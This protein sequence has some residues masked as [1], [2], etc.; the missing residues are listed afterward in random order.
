MKDRRKQAQQPTEQFMLN[1]ID[2]LLANMEGPKDRV[3]EMS[4]IIEPK[5]LPEDLPFQRDLMAVL[6]D[7]SARSI[8]PTRQNLLYGLGVLYSR[9]GTETEAAMDA[10]LDKKTVGGDVNSLSSW[11]TDDIRRRQI[12]DAWTRGDGI[13]NSYEGTPSERLERAITEVLP[14]YTSSEGVSEERET[15]ELMDYMDEELDR[16]RD[17]FLNGAAPGPSLKFRGFTGVRNKDGS[18]KIPGKVPFLKWGQTTLVTGQSKAGKTLFGG[19][20]AEHNAW[21]LNIDVLYIHMETEQV[22]M[23]DRM[24]VRNLFIP[25]DYLG[26][27]L[28]DRKDAT[29][30]AAAKYNRFSKWASLPVKNW[31]NGTETPSGEITFL[32]CPGTT[33]YEINSAIA[34]QRRKSDAR[35]RGLLVI[36]DY[37]NLIDKSSFYGN[38]GEQLGQVAY[39]LREGIKRENSKSQAAKGLGVHC[40]VFAQESVDANGEATG[41]AGTQIVQYSQLH[42][43]ITRTDAEEDLTMDKKDVNALGHQRYW[44]RKGEKDRR[45]ILK[46]VRGNESQRGNVEVWVENA[47]YQA[48]DPVEAAAQLR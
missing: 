33:V 20:W 13:M 3:Y 14:L 21:V 15:S 9:T 35:G 43:S 34:L 25:I 8:A 11:I 18:W 26:A 47:Y 30:A 12:R 37:Y 45:A 23:G 10:I 5:E 48:R 19:I 31:S 24:I 17:Q 1:L 44:H 7:C 4:R 28:L 46:V 38:T 42:I 41:F 16:R 36:V 39:H 2:S 22:T 6:L 32:Y 27:G 29:S 40:I